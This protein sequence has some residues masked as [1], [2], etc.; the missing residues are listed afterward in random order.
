MSCGVTCP[1]GGGKAEDP[2]L[3]PWTSAVQC[4]H[5]SSAAIARAGHTPSWTSWKLS[6][7]TPSSVGLVLA[8]P[9]A[10]GV[11]LPTHPMV[12]LPIHQHPLP[13]VDGIKQETGSSA[14]N[15]RII[16]LAVQGFLCLTIKRR[17]ADWVSLTQ[18]M[19]WKSTCCCLVLY[20]CFPMGMAKTFTP[21]WEAGSTGSPRQSHW[22]RRHLYSTLGSSAVHVD[23]GVCGQP[24]VHFK[25]SVLSQNKQQW[26]EGVALLPSFTL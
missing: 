26:H 2:T 16:N 24:R 19:R 21:C 5:R 11:C 25:G 6:V 7:A 20:S 9:R 18:V 15:S 4:S 13:L 14:S 12:G 3:W 17:N 10:L 23:V 1:T 22:V 8:P